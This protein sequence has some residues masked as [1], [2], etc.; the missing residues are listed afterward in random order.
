MVIRWIEEWRK[1]GK[2]RRR[3]V[4]VVVE[5]KGRR[6]VEEEV[7]GGTAVAEE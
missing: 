3:K 1:G 4:E 2:D 5:G 7:A 6:N